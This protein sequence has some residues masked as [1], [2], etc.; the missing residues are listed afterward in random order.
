MVK[1]SLLE[2]FFL[3]ATASILILMPYGL[4]NYRPEGKLG[5]QY[6]IG[7][8]PVGESP[9]KWIVN[10]EKWD[11][12]DSEN[13]ASEIKVKQGE[14]VSLKISSADVVHVFTIQEYNIS[15]EIY[16]GEIKTLEF[17]ADKA[18][19]FEFYC[20]RGCGLGHLDMKG[21]LIVEP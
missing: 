16:P 11:F 9:G 18:G 10:K 5:S 15:E 3:I 14:K 12:H 4:Y 8:N 19:E 6:I 21:K 20:K 13:R 17:D 7:Q 2:K 1:S